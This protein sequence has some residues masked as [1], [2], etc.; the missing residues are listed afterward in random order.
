MKRSKE[1]FAQMREEDIEIEN[2]STYNLLL[3]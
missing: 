1:V 3:I 2:E